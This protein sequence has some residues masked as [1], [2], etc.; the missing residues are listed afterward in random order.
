MAYSFL[1]RTFMNKKFAVKDLIVASFLLAFGVILP[2]IFHAFGMMGNIFLP[3]H[4]PV[5]IGGFLLPPSLALVLGVLTPLISSVTTGMPVLFP[6]AV[7]MMFELATYGFVTALIVSKTKISNIITLIIS[8]ISGRIVAGFV[9]FV[10][11]AFFNVK[12]S[13]IMFIK[14]AII[15]GLPGIII[16]LIIIP[17]IIIVLKFGFKKG[18]A[19]S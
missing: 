12:M 16:Q 19:K 15:T 2:M 10:L 8:M 6:M 3:M 17:S 1:R 14:G 5:L 11:A 18:I 7:I 9:V 13:P 4:I